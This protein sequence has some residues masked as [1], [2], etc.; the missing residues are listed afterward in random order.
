MSSSSSLSPSSPNMNNNNNNNNNRNN[1]NTTTAATTTTTNDNNSNSNN[2]NDNK[3]SSSSSRRS[4]RV[5]SRPALFTDE[6]YPLTRRKRKKPSKKRKNTENDSTQSIVI[7]KKIKSEHIPNSTKSH[8]PP[9]CICFRSPV[10]NPVKICNRGKQYII[11]SIIFFFH[12]LITYDQ[13]SPVCLII[14]H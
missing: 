11:I 8:L 2:D 12:F 3:T 7:E 6:I 4:T 9:C 5:S 13:S 1:S 10:R 14:I